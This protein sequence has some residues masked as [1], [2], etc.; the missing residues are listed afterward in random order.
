MGRTLVR[1]A[2]PRNFRGLEIDMGANV[3]D[4]DK[5]VP[6]V[7]GV[8]RTEDNGLEISEER[9]RRRSDEKGMGHNVA[10][11]VDNRAQVIFVDESSGVD[12]SHDP[13][14]VVQAGHVNNAC[15]SL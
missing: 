11:E 13:E 9:K 2:A 5:I 4:K 1:V 15:P 10:M 12:G 3:L 14:N 7:S 8:T 6:Y